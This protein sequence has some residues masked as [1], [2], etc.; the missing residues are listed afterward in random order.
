MNF[1]NG[2]PNTIQ[3]NT[4]YIKPKEYKSSKANKGMSL[5]GM[6]NESNLFYLSREIAVIYKKPTP[7]QIVKVDY[8][9]RNK[10]VIREAYYKTPSTTDYNGIYKGYYIDFD[11]KE[12]S[13]KTRYPIHDVFEHQVTHLVRVK[14]QGGIAFLLI[15]FN[16]YNKTYIID[17][18][19]FVKFK[20]EASNGSRH[21]IPYSFFEENCILVKEGYMPQIDYLKGVDILI[22]E[23]E[24]IKG[25]NQK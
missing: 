24:K 4:S 10:T 7:I 25:L 18:D 16:L 9:S 12:C 5:E 1:P 22:K 2:K 23:L 15:R 14:K 6:I 3:K 8:P 21:S 17:I 19:Q 13:T 11:A 20:N